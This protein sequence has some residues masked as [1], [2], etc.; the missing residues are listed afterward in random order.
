MGEVLVDE[1]GR[2]SDN[3]SGTDPSADKRTNKITL[4]LLSFKRKK[5]CPLPVYSTE[6][7]RLTVTES[8]ERRGESTTG[9]A[10]SL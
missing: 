4:A 6:P 8:T 10:E 9:S 2:P 7:L 3:Q 5:I 1:R